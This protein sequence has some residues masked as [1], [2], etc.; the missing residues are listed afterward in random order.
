MTFAVLHSRPLL[1]WKGRKDES[2]LVGDL[3][4]AVPSTVLQSFISF[5]GQ[6]E[7]EIDIQE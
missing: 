5:F 2:V 1:D 3:C 6:L 4:G 7:G